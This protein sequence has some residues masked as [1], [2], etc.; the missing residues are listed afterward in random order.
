MVLTCVSCYV[1]GTGPDSLFGSRKLE[2]HAFNTLNG[3]LGEANRV[4]GLLQCADRYLAYEGADRDLQW[5][6]FYVRARR[7]GDNI[8]C[9]YGSST[10]KV[11]TNGKTFSEPG[12][13][14]KVSGERGLV[15]HCISET[16][17]IV[18]SKYIES[19]LEITSSEPLRMEYSWKGGGTEISVR[20]E[21]LR[22]EYTY[23]IS[24]FWDYKDNPISYHISSYRYTNMIST[25]S[26]HYSVEHDGR[27]IDWLNSTFSGDSTNTTTSRD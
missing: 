10:M 8:V 11:N 17:W 25:G 1:A 20:D 21:T 22:A 7:E 3:N 13:V 2:S 12:A 18:E 5:F 16:S 15:F 27:Q 24:F 14:Y 23:D 6:S 26:F 9:T 4:F 19:E